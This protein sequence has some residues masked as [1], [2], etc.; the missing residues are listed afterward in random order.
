MPRERSYRDLVAWQKAME[1]VSGVYRL[2]ADW[3]A[4]ERFGL[5]NQLRRAAVSVPANIAEGQGCSGATELKRFLF[6]AHGSL[7]EIETHLLI[8]QRL[9]FSPETAITPLLEQAEETGRILR[10]L[11]RSLG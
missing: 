10:G 7:C 2:T 3:P 9:G 8:G 4:D 6:I 5:T 1:S 11:V